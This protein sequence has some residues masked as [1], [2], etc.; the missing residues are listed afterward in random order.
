MCEKQLNLPASPNPATL[1]FMRGK[2]LYYDDSYTTEFEAVVIETAE[3]DGQPVV[4][5]QQSYFYPESG[6]QWCDFGRIHTTNVTNVTIRPSDQATLHHLDNPL[7]LG[8]YPAHIDWTRRFDL[9]QQHTGQHILSQAFARI[10][11]ANTI[12]F[13]MGQASCTIDLDIAKLDETQLQQVEELAN[14]VVWE[15]RPIHSYF[16]PLAEASNYPL[17][18]IPTGKGDQLRV[19]EIADFD[20]NACGGTHVKAT[21][22]VGLIKISKVEKIRRQ[23]RIEFRCGKRA[24]AHYGDL[25]ATM[26]GLTKA[27]TCAPSD[28]LA[29]TSNLRA[30]HK[31]ARKTLKKQQARLLAAEAQQLL[32]DVAN[33]NGVQ[34]VQGVFDKRD[35]ADLRQLAQTIV[36]Q[37]RTIALLGNGDALVF[38]KSKDAPS[39]M[40]ELLSPILTTHNGRGGGAA[41]FAQ[42]M[43]LGMNS[44]EQKVILASVAEKIW[45]QD[46]ENQCLGD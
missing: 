27:F 10:L 36:R 14:Q 3:I 12:G 29:V 45:Q 1:K 42:A 33:P 28:L 22:A 5:L 11:E 26:G 2:R 40:N 30:E 16:I 41:Q 19:V 46:A 25:L 18:K 39:V 32:A 13:H 35:F 20:W 31:Q 34:I 15:N 21:G 17:R 6:G 44:A 43:Q 38:A 24:Y 37:P 7:P 8:T 9:M 4:V 23:L